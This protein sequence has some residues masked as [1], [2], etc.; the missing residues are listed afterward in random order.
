M[1]GAHDNG[2]E[3]S[4]PPAM[5]RRRHSYEH[6]KSGREKE[7]ASPY[8]RG[9]QEGEKREILWA[10]GDSSTPTRRRRRLSCEQDAAGAAGL[11]ARV[12]GFESSRDGERDRVRGLRP[13]GRHVHAKWVRARG[14]FV[15]EVWVL[16]VCVATGHCLGISRSGPVPPCGL[17]H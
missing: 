7:R 3:S 1:L 10:D 6:G 9:W 12:Y 11:G 13:E 14:E 17:L 4:R 16:R 2:A 8:R 15:S 5:R